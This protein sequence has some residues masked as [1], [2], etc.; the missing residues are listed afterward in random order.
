MEL[1]LIKLNIIYPYYIYFL[2]KCNFIYP[3]NNKIGM[4][5]TS[6]FFILFL[7]LI[8][9]SKLCF[10]KELEEVQQFQLTS[11]VTCSEQSTE[12]ENRVLAWTF[13][14]LVTVM[15]IILIQGYTISSLHC[16]YISEAS[17]A[18]L[19]GLLIGISVKYIGSFIKFTELIQFNQEFFFLIL[20][21]PI[22]FE[23]GY[24]MQKVRI[25]KFYINFSYKMFE[26]AKH[27]T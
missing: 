20:L 26:K 19:I 12:L 10:A 25:L 9:F 13:L 4:H 22:I 11:F 2:I 14:M 16:I 15:I 27:K 21:P 3:Y 17:G 8:S 6:T 24:N 1:F 5:T 18:I 7:I 23:S